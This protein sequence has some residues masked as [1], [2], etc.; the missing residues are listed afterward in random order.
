MNCSAAAY[1]QLP[2]QGKD[3]IRR[4][5]SESNIEHEQKRVSEKNPSINV[6]RL[7]QDKGNK[8]SCCLK[9]DRET[10]DLILRGAGTLV[11]LAL[12]VIIPYYGGEILSSVNNALIPRADAI[13]SIAENQIVPRA[14]A[15]IAIAENQIVPIEQG[16][17]VLADQIQ[18]DSLDFD[19][20]LQSIKEELSN[21]TN[22]VAIKD[23]LELLRIEQA[24]KSAEKMVVVY[25]IR[26]ALATK[27]A[28]VAPVN[29]S[30]PA[31]FRLPYQKHPIKSRKMY[32]AKPNHRTDRRG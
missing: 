13:I 16:L 23:R 24:K 28:S 22:V 32:Q 27:T 31:P 30:R 6:S 19:Q 20:D 10:T 26:A 14:D 7:K 12:C 3:K 17:V 1:K 15:I 21:C 29:H 9:K 11:T 8:K 25:A 18:A 2:G 4:I 5:S